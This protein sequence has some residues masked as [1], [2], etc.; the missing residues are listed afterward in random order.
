MEM[1]YDCGTLGRISCEDHE[2]GGPVLIQQWDG[3]KWS[4]GSDWVP[5]M[6]EVVRPKIEAAAVE[7]GQ[8]AGVRDARLLQGEVSAAGEALDAPPL[9]A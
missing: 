2:G 3:R 8:E 4:A 1:G 7:G 6:R 9:P 5:T